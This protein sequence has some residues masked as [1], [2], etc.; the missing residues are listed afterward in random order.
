MMQSGPICSTVGLPMMLLNGGM[1][2]LRKS[3]TLMMTTFPS[4]VMTLRKFPRKS[5]GEIAVRT[6]NKKDLIATQSLS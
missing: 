1:I 4:A 5:I 3:M 2:S 6:D